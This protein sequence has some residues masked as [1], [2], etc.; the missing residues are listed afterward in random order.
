MLGEFILLSYVSL[1][2]EFKA[3]VATNS[4]TACTFTE[5]KAH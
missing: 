4:S 2:K 5:V 3:E 1:I